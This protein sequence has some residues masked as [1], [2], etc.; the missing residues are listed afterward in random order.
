MKLELFDTFIYFAFLW[1]LSSEDVAHIVFQILWTAIND[2]MTFL[3]VHH[4]INEL[5]GNDDLWSDLKPIIK[6]P[7]YNRTN[8]QNMCC[9]SWSINGK[10]TCKDEKLLHSFRGESCFPFGCHFVPPGELSGREQCHS[11]RVDAKKL[12]VFSLRR[13]V[14]VVEMEAI[15]RNV[16]SLEFQSQVRDYS[17]CIQV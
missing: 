4:G 8:N 15:R 9:N 12:D 7:E 1:I 13:D 17:S 16:I 11:C 10:Q 2:E 6:Q 14:T 3:V 5:R